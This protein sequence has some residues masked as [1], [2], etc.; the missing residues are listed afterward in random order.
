ASRTAAAS[1][2][3]VVDHLD[4]DR[5]Q[6][7][8]H[9]SPPAAGCP[10]LGDRVGH[11]P[12]LALVDR[13]EGRPVAGAG[14]GLHLH[15]ADLAA[16]AADEV[17][18]APPALEVAVE[19]LVAEPPQVLGRQVLTRPTETTARQQRALSP[20]SRRSGGWGDRKSTRLN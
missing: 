3:D 7:E 5:D 9:R 6:L 20:A 4:R 10:V 12:L 19:D 1:G 18:L 15:Q 14:A 11:R 13:L 8:A 16:T 17:D 2:E